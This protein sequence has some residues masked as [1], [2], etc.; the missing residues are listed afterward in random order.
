MSKES[1]AVI[2]GG[3]P[4]IGPYSPVVI[5]EGR[6]VFVS[7]QIPYD[8]EAGA[9]VRGSVGEQ[10]EIVL[11]NLKRAVEA[12]GASLADVVSCR[13]YLQPL[14]TSTFAAMNEVYASFFGDSKPARTTL[15]ASLL[16]FD[17]EIE[18]IAVLPS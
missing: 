8:P 11:T 18:A 10:T 16:N 14:N 5:G 6:F 17:V 12:A 1:L 7:G 9:V 13:V 3:P 4:A 2:P 15:G